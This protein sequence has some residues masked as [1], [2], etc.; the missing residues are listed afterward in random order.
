MA[1]FRWLAQVSQIKNSWEFEN[2]GQKNSKKQSEG[3]FKVDFINNF[4]C[5]LSL[6]FGRNIYK[7]NA[8]L[9]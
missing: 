1:D 5:L 8:T 4:S 7:A 2:S 3:Y 9:L 6:S